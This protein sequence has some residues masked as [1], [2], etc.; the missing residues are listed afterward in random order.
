MCIWRLR[1]SHKPQGGH[2]DADGDGKDGTQGQETVV[3]GGTGGEDVVHKENMAISIFLCACFVCFECAFHVGGLLLGGDLGL[4]AGASAAA[5]VIM[6]IV[7]IL[8]FII[9]QS[10]IIETMASSGMKD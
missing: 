8:V 4:G 2:A 6:M 7:P 10:N 9:S 3:E 1:P 5:T